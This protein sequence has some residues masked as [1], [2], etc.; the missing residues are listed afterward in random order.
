MEADYRDLTGAARK[1]MRPSED[2]TRQLRTEIRKELDRTRVDLETT[3]E[4]KVK[5]SVTEDFVEQNR[6]I[7][8][9]SLRIGALEGTTRETT[10][11]LEL[12]KLEMLEL[13]KETA[14]STA[15]GVARKTVEAQRMM[16]NVADLRSALYNVSENVS[17]LSRDMHG[18]RASPVAPAAASDTARSIASTDTDLDNSRGREAASQS[19]Q[20]DGVS[21]RNGRGTPRRHSPAALSSRNV[22][23]QDVMLGNFVTAKF[24]E[25]PEESPGSQLRGVSAMFAQA[26]DSSR[27]MGSPRLR[28]VSPSSP[29]GGPVMKA[30][31]TAAGMQRPPTD[32]V[33]NSYVGPSVKDSNM[34]HASVQS[35]ESSSVEEPSLHADSSRRAD[36]PVATS[37]TR[38]T[39]VSALRP[40]TG[41]S[42]NGARHIGQSRPSVSPGKESAMSARVVETER[43]KSSSPLRSNGTR[44]V[45]MGNLAQTQKIV[46]NLS[47]R[48]VYGA[49]QRVGPMPQNEAQAR[50]AV[51]RFISE[52]SRLSTAQTGAGLNESVTPRSRPANPTNV[53][54]PMIGCVSPTTQNRTGVRV[55]TTPVPKP[56]FHGGSYSPNVAGERRESI[57]HNFAVRQDASRGGSFSARAGDQTPVPRAPA[58]GSVSA[59]VGRYAVDT[60]TVVSS[61]SPSGR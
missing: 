55:A 34:S 4:Q 11:K 33:P 61:L 35:G 39:P 43:F 46:R 16:F 31:I 50:P 28:Q 60:K 52:D 7:E 17:R 20:T 26:G 12:A 14:S 47:P 56:V 24:N 30:A 18:L 32:G 42:I 5:A 51:H 53:E 37:G 1:S 36:N 13:C 44:Y 19:S 9:V 48:I 41:V 2:S 29:K 6:V 21:P 10:H 54:Q 22:L 49:R 8:K 15:A 23:D 57:P 27:P 3:L 40:Q 25:M 45:D 58:G 59:P 38:S